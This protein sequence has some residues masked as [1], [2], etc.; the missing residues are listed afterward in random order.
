[1]HGKRYLP[2]EEFIPHHVRTWGF[3]SEQAKEGKLLGVPLSL[4]AWV[5]LV[6]S[7][8]FFLHYPLLISGG[9]TNFISEYDH[10]KDILTKDILYLLVFALNILHIT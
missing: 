1:M 10:Q 8:F 6:L 5:L 7:R 3:Q 2:L 9:S 4:C